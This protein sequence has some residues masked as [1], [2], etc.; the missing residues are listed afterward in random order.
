M[1]SGWDASDPVTSPD[2]G[3]WDLLVVGGG[4]AGIVA[5]Q[6]AA[7]FGA[8]VLLAERDRTGGD[9]L[10]TGCVP[11]KAILSAAHAVADAR[12]AG[13]FGVRVDGTG[14]DFGAVMAHVRAAIAA[15]APVDSPASLRAAGVR[16]A[17]GEARL[18]GP[19]SAVINGTGIR[20]RRAVLATGA[21]PV[22][23]PIPGLT[24]TRPLTSDT[25]WSMSALPGRLLVIGGGSIGCELGQ[26]FAR[27]GSRVT[28]VDVAERLLPREDDDAVAVLA[29]QLAADGVTT[30]TGVVVTSVRGDS[31]GWCAVL[32][33]GG[34]VGFD[35]V[36]V[37]VGRRP[38][39][40]GLGLE[41]AGVYLDG[42]GFVRVDSRMRTSNPR[43]FAAGDVTPYP[44]FTHT[45]G[46]YG[47]NAATNAILG[48][49]R[50]ARPATVGRVTFT[51]PEIAAV[52]VG[53]APAGHLPGFTARTVPHTEVDRAVTDA[54]TGGFT[55]VVFDRRSR[56]AGATIVGPRA[57]ESLPEIV[58]A[59][60]HGLRARDLAGAMHAYPTYGDG[61]WKAC[62]AQI[63]GQLGR[64]A[65][66]RV[67][68]ALR[69]LHHR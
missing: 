49:R 45:A 26:A 10:W 23:P 12:D 19:R 52:G 69:R 39:T 8:R 65:A 32:D 13:R 59:M 5:A 53:A 37:A 7:G 4:T 24:E 47:G 38:R 28:I 58:L 11:S 20:F 29:A 63:R 57:G 35:D 42:H 33:D 27:L 40:T 50:R 48:L 67:I 62:I 1:T 61:V 36:L 66:R 18:T 64:P 41:A 60:R 21:A 68:T 25:V 55:R 17:H 46:V 34:A 2:A 22:L 6:T 44:P 3:G 31:A 9:C 43:I 16:V 30:R 14:V 54:D 56:V 51:R 15:I